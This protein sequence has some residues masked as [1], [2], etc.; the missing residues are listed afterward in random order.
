MY[1]PYDCSRMICNNSPRIPSLTKA[2]CTLTHIHCCNSLCSE[3]FLP[4]C[5][6]PFVALLLQTFYLKRRRRERSVWLYP[7]AT[8]CLDG[9]LS[10]TASLFS[11]FMGEYLR[12]LPFAWGSGILLNQAWREIDWKENTIMGKQFIPFPLTE[13]RVLSILWNK[14]YL[15]VC[16]KKWKL[17]I[18]LW[19]LWSLFEMGFFFYSM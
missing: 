4:P 5:C 12:L 10:L 11:P 19:W 14:Y 7:C 17:L 13:G 3:L 18:S 9:T 8:R 15:P 2:T 16:F 6:W 1:T